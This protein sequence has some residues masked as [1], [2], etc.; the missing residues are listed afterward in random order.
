VLLF[1]QNT[2]GFKAPGEYVKNALATVTTHDLPTLH[3][4]WESHDIALREKLSLYPSEAILK[5]VR[6]AR[7]NELPAM[8][9]ALVREGL[10]HW[11]PAQGLPPYSPA[12]AR[13]I[14]AFL[15]LT[16]ANFAMLQIEDLIGMIDPVNVPGTDKEHANWQRKVALNTS[17]IFVRSDVRDMLDAVNRARH[18]E[19]PSAP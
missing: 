3:S 15:G 13:A 17:D 12:L 7:A 8:M 11:D 14:H 18:G 9:A 6:E 5:S 16:A 19:N 1:E 4:W 10:W 2:S